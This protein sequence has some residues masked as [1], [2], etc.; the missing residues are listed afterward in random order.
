[1]HTYLKNESQLNKFYAEILVH[2]FRR[3]R[4]MEKGDLWVAYKENLILDAYFTETIRGSGFAW[5]PEK[6]KQV[7]SE[8]KIA[9]GKFYES[10][11]ARDDVIVMFG[12]ATLWG[13]ILLL[14]C[15]LSALSAGGG[16]AILLKFK[17]ATNEAG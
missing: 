2:L 10:P 12:P 16:D 6:T 14:V 1:M 4:Y 9:P 13:F 17:W 3:D 5:P 15:I 11:V 7:E 8:L